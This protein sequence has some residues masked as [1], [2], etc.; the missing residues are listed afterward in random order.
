VLRGIEFKMMG[1]LNLTV[2]TYEQPMKKDSENLEEVDEN[3][4]G[5]AKHEGYQYLPAHLKSGTHLC[6]C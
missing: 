6:F 1:F 5:H 2:E 3:K 4:L